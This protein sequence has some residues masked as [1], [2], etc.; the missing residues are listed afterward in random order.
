MPYTS[1]Y[2]SISLYFYYLCFNILYFI[3]INLCIILQLLSEEAHKLETAE[4]FQLKKT[5]DKNSLLETEMTDWMLSTIQRAQVSKVNSG[6]S[7]LASG[8]LAQ[9]GQVKLQNSLVTDFNDAIKQTSASPVKMLNF[10]DFYTM[11]NEYNHINNNNNNSTT[12]AA[13]NIEQTG[14]VTVKSPVDIAGKRARRRRAT[15]GNIGPEGGGGSSL[16]DESNSS[17]TLKTRN[18]NIVH[19]ATTATTSS[20]AASAIEPSNLV[21]TLADKDK[22]FEAYLKLAQHQCD[23]SGSAESGHLDKQALMRQKL[24]AAITAPKRMRKHNPLGRSAV[25][26]VDS[27]GQASKDAKKG[28]GN[29]F[30]SKTSCSDTAG[31]DEAV[32]EDRKATIRIDSHVSILGTDNIMN[33]LTKLGKFLACFLSSVAELV[34]IAL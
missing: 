15:E 32:W 11:F 31:P 8:G 18:S 1:M 19:T 3:S 27:R 24:N 34:C 12:A 16:E 23:P 22:N 33:R 20:T 13:T 7:M 5:R 17:V 25:N 14:S 6:T 30:Q 26:L 29:I 9:S 2:I 4:S 28:F 21:K 10:E